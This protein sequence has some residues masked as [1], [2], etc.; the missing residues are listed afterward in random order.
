MRELFKMSGSFLDMLNDREASENVSEELIRELDIMNEQYCVSTHDVPL[1]IQDHLNQMEDEGIPYSSKK[2][3]AN[4]V[5]RFEE[6]LK[7]RNLSGNLLK[8]P[9][10][11]LN[12]YL[13]YFYIG[14]FV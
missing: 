4:T 14:I 1:E 9:K 6:F 11:F 10:S 12:N 5:K 2:Q 8:V 7:A 13:R 3:M